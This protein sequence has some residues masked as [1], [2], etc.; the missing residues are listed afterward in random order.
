MFNKKFWTT[1][2]TLSGTIVGAG[3]LGLPYVFSQSGFFIGVFWLIF[4][5]IVMT[6]INLYFGEIT[7]RTRKLHQ[8]PGY[9]EKYIGKKG[10]I[11]S[12]I[13]MIFGIYAALIAYLIG[14]GQSLSKLFFGNLDYSVYF[15]VGFWFVMA[16]ILRKS[17]KGLKKIGSYGVLAVIVIVFL[18]FLKFVPSVNIEN[19]TYVDKGNFFVP[20]GVV[21]FSMLGFTAIPELE[22]I[23]DGK[24]LKKAIIFGS[25]IPAVLYL[26]FTFVLVGVFGKNVQQIATLSFGNTVTILGIFTMSTAF[27][28]LSFAL[29]DVFIFDLR[30]RKFVFF[31]VSLFPLLI[32][33]IV[34][35]FNLANFVSIIGIGGAVS[36][37]L[38]G[39]LILLMAMK[40]KE[41][42]DRKPEFSLRLNFIIVGVLSLLFIAG[43]IF[44]LLNFIK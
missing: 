39:I 33:L 29:R 15:A 40:A 4:L 13:V 38:T 42:G 14:E 7:L 3:I 5:G 27:F 25:L 35:F 34:S 36:G 17:L 37:G 21:L 2:F 16:F 28:I 44:E 41:E 9:A 11:F 10:K 32:Y 30:K 24:K 20:L 1:V 26:V 43:I 6:I 19:L 22:R 23:Q 18:I 31:W 12:F 8:L